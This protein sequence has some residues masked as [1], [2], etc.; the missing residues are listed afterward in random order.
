MID[1]SKLVLLRNDPEVAAEF[2]EAAEQGDIHA[3]YGL[4]LIYAE[5][6]GVETDLA[7]ACVWLTLAREAGDEDAGVLLRRVIPQMSNADHDRVERLLPAQRQRN[8]MLAAGGRRRRRV[9]P[10]AH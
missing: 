2:L 9:A 6:R 7:H 4:G 1:L 5:G 3:Q 10:R 8:A